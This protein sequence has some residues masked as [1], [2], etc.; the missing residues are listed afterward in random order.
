MEKVTVLSDYNIDVKAVLKCV[1]SLLSAKARLT[2][3]ER[4]FF[5]RSVNLTLKK[6]ANTHPALVWYYSR[7]LQLLKR[8]NFTYR[9][10][11]TSNF[12]LPLLL[13]DT[14]QE[15]RDEWEYY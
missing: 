1:Y 8:D 14:D 11:S 6:K 13:W 2:A 9:I 5:L 4:I 10:N 3:Y 7:A 15:E 12:A